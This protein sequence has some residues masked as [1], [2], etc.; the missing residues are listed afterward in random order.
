MIELRIIDA[1]H[2]ADIRLPNQPFEL[3]G[4][5]RPSYIDG[6]WDYDTER[7]AEVTRMCF[8][9]EDYDYAAMADEFAF[10]GAYDG[11]QCVGLAVMRDAMFKYM[12]L[13]DLKVSAEYRGRGVGSALIA[14]AKRL[15][16]ERGYRGVYVVAQDNNLAAC[17][18]YIKCG[19]RIGGLDTDVYLGTSQQGKADI[20]FYCEC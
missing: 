13:Y 2:G 7:F 10:I 16:S 8:P 14:A 11:G 4:R 6:K 19:F 1:A 20:T 5:M 18:L 15:A 17:L 12:Y 3:I 9:D